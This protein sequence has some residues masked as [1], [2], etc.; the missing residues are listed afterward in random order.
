MQTP[1]LGQRRSRLPIALMILGPLGFG[2]GWLI[3]YA[4]DDGQRPFPS[5]QI[6]TPSPA[7]YT[8]PA[9]SPVQMLA[10]PPAKPAS[11]SPERPAPPATTERPA[12]PTATTPPRPATTT[13]PPSTTPATDD[14]VET[15]TTPRPTRDRTEGDG[16]SR[17][18][19]EGD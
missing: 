3:G 18:R 5:E 12:A 10:P 14:P 6:S 1:V 16:D 4:L 8:P 13:P 9:T 17:R 7:T 15:T 19:D 11:R 2:G